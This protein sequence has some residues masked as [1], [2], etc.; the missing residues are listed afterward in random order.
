MVKR[1]IPLHPVPPLH[2]PA[3]RFA[4]NAAG[5][6]T[7]SSALLHVGQQQETASWSVNTAHPVTLDTLHRPLR[8]LRISV[9][10]RCNFRCS[11][12]M[13]KAVFN[14]RYSYLEQ[15][16]LLSF[17][18][19]TRLARIFLSLGVQKIRLT[20]GEPLLRKHLDQLVTQ[21][22]A[23]RT[24]EGAP[25]DLTLTTNGS[26]LK[27]WAVPLRQAGLQ[28]LTVS[29][30]GLDD[31][32]FQRMND[33]GYP[34]A[35]VLAG[36]DAAQAAGFASIKVN[37]VVQ[38]GVNE[39]QVVPMARYFYGSGI[40]LRFIEYMDVGT[41]N[42]WRIQEVVPSATLLEQL[43]TQF[44][45]H[46]LPCS[47]PGET[48]QRW[49]YVNA[50]GHVDP[51]LGELGF[52]S[53]VSQA[54]CSDC[55]RV[56]L[57]TKGDMYLCLFACQGWDLR[58]LLRTPQANGNLANDDTI[59]TTIASIWHARSDQYSALRQH[60]NETSETPQHT[61]RVEMSY[62]GG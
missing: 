11:Y 15:T 2:K 55:N 54:F 27:R 6:L 20:G 57:S 12:C 43:Q 53:S 37:M 4:P 46:A 58:S 40:A 52:I 8:D 36:I 30:D 61:N 35:E 29:L 47:T 16:E 25:P 10:D 44:T 7:A 33:V 24:T 17:E 14:D 48:A 1:M 51:T 21:L 60:A 13:P 31:A 5:A 42:G 59:R 9:T 41:T 32:A 34:V 28:R 26:L 23:L 56:R 3:P 18:E 19:I 49:G 62:I 39:N 22:A 45:L 38:R 50:Q